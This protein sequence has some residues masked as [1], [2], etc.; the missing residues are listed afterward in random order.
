MKII[1]G[2]KYHIDKGILKKMAAPDPIL[3]SINGGVIQS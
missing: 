3:H 2:V 1:E